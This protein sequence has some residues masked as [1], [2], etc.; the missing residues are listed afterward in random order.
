[1]EARTI[2][3]AGACSR[4]CGWYPSLK[5][6][7]GGRGC[8]RKSGGEPPHSKKEEPKTQAYTPCL[9]HPAQGLPSPMMARRLDVGAEAPTPVATIYEMASSLLIPSRKRTTCENAATL[10]NTSPKRI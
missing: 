10:G 5:R 9:G 6:S 1:M 8:I 4:F 7:I 3:S 2:W